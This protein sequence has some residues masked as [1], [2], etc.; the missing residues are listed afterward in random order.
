MPDDFET[1]LAINEANVPEV[2]SLDLER[3]A[4]L[5]A[6]SDMA[7]VVD[8]GTPPATRPSRLLLVLGPGSTYQSVNYRWFMDRYD[9]AMYL[10]RVAFDAEFQ[11]LGLGTALVR[12]GARA[13]ALAGMNRW[14][15]EVN[16]RPRNVPSLAFHAASGFVEVGQQDTRHYGITLV[17]LMANESP[18]PDAALTLTVCVGFRARI[19]AVCDADRSRGMA[20]SFSG[21]LGGSGSGRGWTR[22]DRCR[23]RRTGSSRRGWPVARISPSGSMIA[24]SPE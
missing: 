4:F 18:R 6:E 11:G 17:S 14:T 3:L 23:C 2:S 19:A 21:G 10:D 16:C 20:E 15:L 24:L 9:D 8:V 5:V 7:L 13:V 22:R 1:V 12:R